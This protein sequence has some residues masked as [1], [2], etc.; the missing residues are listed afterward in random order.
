M[1]VLLDDSLTIFK[2]YDLAIRDSK[3]KIQ[4]AYH[5][6]GIFHRLHVLIE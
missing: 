3:K 6:G 1:H 5:L 2:K 4:K